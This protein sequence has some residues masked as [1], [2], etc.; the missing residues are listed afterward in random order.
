MN[1]IVRS[2]RAQSWM[3]MIKEQKESGLSIASWC[4]EN[5][6]SENCYYYR[7]NKLRELAAGEFLEFVEIK[8]PVTTA[9]RSAAMHNENIYGTACIR[10]G[11]ITIELTNDAG[12]DLIRNIV[13]A[14]HA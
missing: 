7:K 5:G 8:Q 3:Q 4:R 6:V 11:G 2:V 1:Q 12:Q 10:Y 14:L 13:G 9:V